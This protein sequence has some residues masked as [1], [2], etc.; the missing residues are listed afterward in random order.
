M[1][2][3]SIGEYLN[4]RVM[5]YGERKV[6]PTAG[7]QLS[8]VPVPAPVEE[9]QQILQYGQDSASYLLGF[10]NREYELPPYDAPMGEEWANT[11]RYIAEGVENIRLANC[12]VSGKPLYDDDDEYE[13]DED[14][15]EQPKTKKPKK[16]KSSFL[17]KLKDIFGDD[18]DDDD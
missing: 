17:S 12:V 7:Y 16:S 9:L 10:V 13:L 4:N 14:V 1:G 15:E 18:D 8:G 6:N 11:F 3:M 5:V 2:T